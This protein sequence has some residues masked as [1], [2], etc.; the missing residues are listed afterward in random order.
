MPGWAVGP[1][2][3]PWA[4]GPPRELP[5]PRARPAQVSTAQVTEEL[6]WGRRAALTRDGRLV[7][8]VR[9]SETDAHGCGRAAGAL[10]GSAPGL[11]PAGLGL[12]HPGSPPSHLPL[13]GA[14]G[15]RLPETLCEAS[16]AHPGPG[17][18]GEVT[19]CWPWRQGRA[20]GQAAEVSSASCR[21]RCMRPPPWFRC[22]EAGVQIVC[23]PVRKVGLRAPGA[24][25]RDPPCEG[26]SGPAQPSH[27]L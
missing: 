21:P 5:C 14:Q 3:T 8:Q 26:D 18:G 20:G 9:T 4:P 12:S 10:G 17:A 16:H 23:F 22:Q 27:S 25:T 1:L 15:V 19:G 6:G 11:G 7:G 13:P 2:C 24:G